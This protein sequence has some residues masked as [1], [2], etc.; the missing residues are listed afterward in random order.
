MIYSSFTKY[1]KTGFLVLIILVAVLS[2]SCGLFKKGDCNECP[3]FGK[4]KTT[5]SP[6]V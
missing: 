3:K 2:S 6:S 4:K 1:L 5:S